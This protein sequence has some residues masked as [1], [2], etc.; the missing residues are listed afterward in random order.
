MSNPISLQLIAYNDFIGE[1]LVTVFW[2]SADQLVLYPHR[3]EIPSSGEER[4]HLDLSDFQW[5]AYLSTGGW[6][7]SHLSSSEED[8]RCLASETWIFAAARFLWA[9]VP[10]DAICK[11]SRSPLG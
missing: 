2:D 3:R 4:H 5:R 6:T 11:V 7:T 8:T 10:S 1:Q 9:A